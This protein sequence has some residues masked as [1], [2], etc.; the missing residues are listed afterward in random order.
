MLLNLEESSVPMRR[1]YLF[2]EEIKHDP[3]Y[4]EEVQNL[5]LDTSRPTM[6]L[7]GTH[8]LF[9]SEEWWAS[10]REGRIPL[11]FVSG[12]IQRIYV[13]GQ[14]AGVVNNTIDLVLEDGT[15]VSTGIYTND[16]RDVALFCLGHKA[17][18]VYAL[19]ELKCPPEEEAWYYSETALEMAVSED[20]IE[21]N[22]KIKGVSD[23]LNYC[24]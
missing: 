11:K 23:G 24:Q 14:D 2:T 9:C 4:V 3:S 1:V 20:P 12:I 15:K 13:T 7:K 17:E 16:K 10:I 22:G 8:G 18:I 19:D 21:G 6:G 5:T